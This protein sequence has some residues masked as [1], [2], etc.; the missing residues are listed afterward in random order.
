MD[1]NV[2]QVI[3][4]VVYKLACLSVGALFGVLGYKLF[5]AGIWGN[6]GDVEAIFSNN[7]V[8][9]KNGTPGGFFALVGAG[10]VIYTILKGVIMPT[11]ETSEVI[12]EE[13]KKK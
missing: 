3:G 4:L 11:H 1:P 2:T 8:V 5:K 6:S 7:K 12:T 13:V 10:I 9:Y